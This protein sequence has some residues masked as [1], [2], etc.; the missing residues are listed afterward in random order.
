MLKIEE[1][2]LV[3]FS[4]GQD[5]TTCLIWALKKFKKVSALTFNYKQRHNVEIECAKN[6]I[7]ILNSRKDIQLDWLSNKNVID[8]IIVDIPFLSRLL[9]T[10][11]IQELEIKYDK[12]GLPTTFVPGRNIL[13][14]TIAASYA[15]QKKIRHIICGVCQ[16]DYS[17]YPDCRDATI[18]SLQATLKLGLDYDIIIHTPLMWKNKAETIKLMQNQGG[19]DLFKYTHTCYK[20][21]RPACGKCFACELRLKGFKEAGLKDPLEYKSL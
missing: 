13:F 15:Y 11:M 16:T 4:G 3:V 7:E 9:K 1:P 12:N 10:A 5:S 20:G 18:K 19:L 8:H 17:G 14:L 21:E 2:A 6:I